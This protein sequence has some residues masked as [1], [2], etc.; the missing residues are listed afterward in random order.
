MEKASECELPFRQFALTCSLNCFQALLCKAPF[1]QHF[2]EDF[3]SE[4]GGS[5]SPSGDSEEAAQRHG[6]HRAEDGVENI[7]DQQSEGGIHHP[8]PVEVHR[9]TAVQ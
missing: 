6:G 5:L 1:L 3:G 8:A 4:R 2:R 9:Q 7:Q